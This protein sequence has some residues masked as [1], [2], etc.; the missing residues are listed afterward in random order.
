MGDFRQRVGLV[1]ELRQLRRSEELA[2]RGDRR[3]GVDQV[4]RHD[5][6]HVDRA[7]PLLDR[8]L[9]AQ[10]PDAILVLEQLADRA[11]AAVGEVVDVV[12]LALAVL[13]VHQLLDD[14]EDVFLAQRRDGVL[15]VEA[16]AHVELHP[17]D[18]G[19]VIA[20][21]VEEQAVEQSVGGLARRRLAGAHDAV[22]V[23]QRAVAVFA[24]VGLE[25]VAHPRAGVDVIDVE[26]LELV[27]LGLVELLEVL[28]RDL[29]AGLD[30]DLAGLLVDQII[31]RIAAE[32]FLGRDDEVLDPVLAGLVCATRGDLLVGL[33]DDF[34]GVG[35]D[36][37]VGRLH[38]AP[39]FRA[40]RD[41][42]A[43][44]AAH[45]TDAVVEGVED[46]LAGHAERVEQ[47]GHR[48]L[49][50]AVD[51][52]VD[53]VLGVEL[54]V[55]PAAAVGDDPRGEQE[56]A[57]GVGLAAIVV[58]Q[59]ARRAVHLA[60]DHALGAVDDEGAVHRHERHVAHVH[61]LLLDI[62]D[63]LG[64]GLGIDL[65]GGQAQ[66]D[67]HRRGVGQPALAALVGVVLGR[68]ELIMIEVEMRGA[69]EI[70]DREHRAQRLL[71]A[72]DIA[73]LGIGAEELLVAFALNLDEVRHF[74]NLVDVAEDLADAP[75]IDLVRALVTRR[76]DRFGGHV[77]P[78]AMRGTRRSSAP[79][80][81]SGVNRIMF[82]ALLPSFLS[83]A[84]GPCAV[85]DPVPERTGKAPGARHRAAEP[86][87]CWIGPI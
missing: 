3:L 33:E 52:D 72:R 71:E 27:G 28:G 42:P 64:L 60:D 78:C 77:L 17:A 19:Q 76:V 26:Q 56:L 59:H 51:A 39:G 75:L 21:G 32:D 7:H 55:E 37:L 74:R 50:L 53:D 66:R 85:S 23:G 1:H 87:I 46:F 24:L 11:H 67:A 16:K 35:I 29:V 14:R 47:R 61:V 84:C 2:H 82:G 40:V 20:L 8:A 86:T 12:D 25:R 45:K 31:G 48:Q 30:V 65:E 68:L 57:A 13:E 73:R 79:R 62:D 81:F 34:P 58:E 44:L 36:D 6:R 70:D 63:R 49:A 18:R 22:D 38:A 43:V 80:W 5:R 83:N 54:E 69:G 9:H 4:V 10:Q 15:G 41:L